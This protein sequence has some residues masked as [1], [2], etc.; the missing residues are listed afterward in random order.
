MT[1][2]VTGLRTWLAVRELPAA[3]LTT[4]PAAQS[5]APAKYKIKKAR[6]LSYAA[7]ICLV[8]A[9][10]VWYLGAE[11]VFFGILIA[12]IY[13]VFSV[14]LIFLSKSVNDSQDTNNDFFEGYLGSPITGPFKT[15]RILRLTAIA[16]LSIFLP[17]GA[18][19]F[20]N[21]ACASVMFF[22]LVFL[23]QGQ[24]GARRVSFRKLIIQA[25]LIETVL[26]ITMVVLAAL[27]LPTAPNGATDGASNPQ[28]S[29]EHQSLH[30]YKWFYILNLTLPLCQLLATIFRFDYENYEAAQ[31][32]SPIIA[33]A[34]APAP[35]AGGLTTGVIAPSWAAVLRVPFR[36][37]YFGAAMAAWVCSNYIVYVLTVREVIPDP[38][39]NLYIFLLLAI[40]IP[41]IIATVVGMAWVRGE[42]T[43]LWT[44]EEVWGD[45]PATDLPV[46]EK[47]AVTAESE[48]EGKGDISDT[49]V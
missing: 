36:C 48:A 8:I 5:D 30:R 19:W 39:R 23:H 38:D 13:P 18:I 33:I 41:F 7:A 2:S 28:S 47:P 49:V 1:R 26:V 24:Q 15:R 45:A 25:A 44:Y 31:P 4:L 16:I 27:L 9:A 29:N 43:R 12:L 14:M 21:E 42:V 11:Y 40:S 32:T 6:L 17:T 10:A 46:A 20:S 35:A 34:R 3:Q 37:Y 22:V